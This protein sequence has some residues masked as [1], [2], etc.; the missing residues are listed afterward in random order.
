MTQKETKT[1]IRELSS[2][3]V[4]R[5]TTIYSNAIATDEKQKEEEKE[6][7]EP[8]TDYADIA[9]SSDDDIAAWRTVGLEALGRG[10]IA[11]LILAGGQGTRLGFE[12]PKGA[13]DIGLPSGK[14]LFQLFFERILRLQHLIQVEGA[15]PGANIP[16]YIMTSQMNHDSTLDFLKKHEYFGLKESQVECFPQGTLPCLTTEGRIMLETR[17]KVA[18]ASDGNGGVYRALETSGS[19][20][21]MEKKGVN[22][23]HVFSVDNALTRPADPVFLGFCMDQNAQC[24]NK[25]VWKNDGHERVGVVVKRNGKYSVVEYSELDED[26]ATM[27]ENDKLVYGAANICNHLFSLSFLKDRAVSDDLPYHIAH[28]KIPYVGSDGRTVRPTKNTGIK[29][30]SFIFDVFPMAESMAILDVS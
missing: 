26:T 7:I 9:S 20:D 21:D 24:G 23:V 13:Y 14:S 19:L 2:I 1:L 17:C 5:V 15:A 22:F 4:E 3:D 11:V 10:E 18:R 12:G 25:V 16:V 28:K 27:V 8:I 6:K 30:E 29:L